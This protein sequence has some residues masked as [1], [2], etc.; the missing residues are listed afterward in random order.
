MDPDQNPSITPI[1]NTPPPIIPHPVPNFEIP[2]VQPFAQN[3]PP[4]QKKF[5][6]KKILI[7]L[8]A[9]ILIFSLTFS[10]F[11]WWVPKAQAEEFIEKTKESFLEVNKEVDKYFSEFADIKEK[12]AIALSSF[13]EFNKLR[14]DYYEAVSDNKQDINDIE[15]VL[16]KVKAAVAEIESL[17]KPQ[18][19]EKLSVALLDYYS[20]LEKVLEELLKIQKDTQQIMAANGNALYDATKIVE[21]E[22]NNNIGGYID[23]T[24]FVAEL[25]A[26]SPL[27]KSAEERMKG[28]SNLGPD[29]QGFSNRVIFY[30]QTLQEE[31]PKIADLIEV[32]QDKAALD[33]IDAFG[34]KVTQMNDLTQKNADEKVANSQL[35]KDIIKLADLEKMVNVEFVALGVQIPQEEEKKASSSAEP[36]E[37]SSSSSPSASPSAQL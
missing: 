24:K 28:L 20:N 9:L 21:D 31:I 1:V 35:A 19:V 15:T 12:G 18:K 7:P 37:S 13:Y 32:G 30:Y 22:I 26:I 4:A 3:P 14:I 10:Y 27:A 34:T 11:F 8:L 29:G 16:P 5:G 36:K 2:V 6:L 17:E 23:R 33:A 25:R